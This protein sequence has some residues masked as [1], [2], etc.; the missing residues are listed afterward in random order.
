VANHDNAPACNQCGRNEDIETGICQRVL[1]PLVNQL[2]MGR[3]MQEMMSPVGRDLL[4]G[5]IVRIS[6]NA[7]DPSLIMIKSY[8]QS[9]R[10]FFRLG[11]GARFTLRRLAGALQKFAQL[12]QFGTSQILIV[13]RMQVM[14][15][16][17][18]F[19]HPGIARLTLHLA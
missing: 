5:N 14:P 16:A 2:L 1:A 4:P 12:D 9:G 13:W 18:N 17:S 3:T 7:I 19:H 6:A 11:E 8:K 10:K 15:F